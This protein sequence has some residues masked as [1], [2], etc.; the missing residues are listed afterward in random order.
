MVQNGHGGS[1]YVAV[2][3][4]SVSGG[5]GDEIWPDMVSLTGLV[6]VVEVGEFHSEADGMGWE[7]EIGSRQKW[8]PRLA[9]THL[10]YGRIPAAPANSLL[11][12][13]PWNES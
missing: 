8:L 11:L 9:S 1:G 3:V 13:E 10:I 6:F 4:V 5:S 2:P 12:Y 7:L